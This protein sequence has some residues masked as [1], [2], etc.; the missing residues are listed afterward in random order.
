MIKIVI[1]D[2]SKPIS[3][4]LKIKKF[5]TP[6]FVNSTF[7]IYKN[8]KKTSMQPI[9]KSKSTSFMFNKKIC[10]MEGKKFIHRWGGGMGDHPN[11]YLEV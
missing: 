11:C 6:K 1:L 4:Y 3:I 7:I 9:L 10:E 2:Q 8:G 5:K